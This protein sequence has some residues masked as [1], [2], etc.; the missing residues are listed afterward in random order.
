MH[1][2]IIFILTFFS[3]S[4]GQSLFNR[5]TGSDPFIGS[6]KS[7]AM[8][9]THLINSYGSTNARFN[10]ASLSHLPSNLVINLQLDRNTTFE[11]WSM[12][13]RDSFDE[14][15]T[16]ADY[17]AN[18]NNYNHLRFGLALAI[19]NPIL[20]GIGLNHSPLSHFSYKYLEEIRGSYSLADG[21]LA[22]KDPVIGFHNLQ[23]S[24]TIMVTS[25]GI[26][27]YLIDLNKIKLSV[28]SS[29]NRMHGT[30][31]KDYVHIDTLYSDVDNLSTYPEINKK[32]KTTSSEFISLSTRLDYNSKLIFSLSWEDSSK[33]I[34][35]DFLFYTDNNL[36]Y[37]FWQ[38][39]NFVAN[40]I[41]YMKPEIVSIALSFLSNKKHKTSI[42]FEINQIYYHNHLHLKNYN[43]IKFG[44]EHISQMGTPIRA[45]L[46]YQT[47]PINGM[48]P[49]S[50]FTFGTGKKIG[51]L[52]LDATGTYSIQSYNYPDLFPVQNDIRPDYDL[53]RESSLKIYFAISYNF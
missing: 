21:E 11:R 35:D 28:G 16:N 24:G 1:Y 12:P 29:I 36:Q 23:T 42:N 17:A 26:G 14:F 34:T 47:S 50:I 2:K 22:S 52:S 51:N 32:S 18:K 30:T 20:M 46:I 43:M 27:I 6:A 44:F 40:G 38:N 25:I 5:W 33:Q 4:F 49:Y 45:G 15:L 8:G 19:K 13:V 7:N 39:N 48:N 37:Q 41:N 53:I 31:V 10:P 3:I 9:S